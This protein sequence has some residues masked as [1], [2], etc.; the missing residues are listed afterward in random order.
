MTGPDCAVN[1]VRTQTCFVGS[2]VL[3]SVRN[4]NLYIFSLLVVTDEEP[5]AYHISSPVDQ[6]SNLKRPTYVYP[7]HTFN[8]H[9]LFC[10]AVV[11]VQYHLT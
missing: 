5:C 10:T 4:N 8:T 7:G 3:S 1:Q 9:T 6:V 2:L 11:V